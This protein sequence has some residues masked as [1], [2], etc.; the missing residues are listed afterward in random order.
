MIT[1]FC[2]VDGIDDEIELIRR[3]GVDKF[4]ISIIVEERVDFIHTRITMRPLIMGLLNFEKLISEF[5]KSEL[6]NFGLI[7]KSK[8]QNMQHRL[9]KKA[10]SFIDLNPNKSGREKRSIE[11][12]GNLIAKAFGNPGPEDWRK[13][14][15]NILA[16]KNAIARQRDNSILLHHTIDSNL[17]YIEKHNEILKKFAIDLQSDENRISMTENSMTELENYFKIETLYDAINEIIESLIDIKRDGKIGRCNFRGFSKDF[18]ITNLRKIESNRF[19]IS[20]VFASWEWENYFKYEMCTVALN[21]DEIW[22]TMRIPIIKPSEKMARII[23]NPSFIWIK[24]EMDNLGIEVSFF[25]EI[26]HDIFAVMS[27]S[28]FETC[29]ILGTTRICNIRKTKFKESRPF[30]VPIAISSNRLILIS[31]VS[32][33]DN[34]KL[35]TECNDMKQTFSLDKFAFI[36]IPSNCEIKNKHFEVTMKHKNEFNQDDIEIEPIKI[37]EYKK[38]ANLSKT[39]EGFIIEN[40]TRYADKDEFE[41][42]TNLTTLALNQI[43]LNHEGISDDI[44]L[45]KAG[46]ISGSAIIG[47]LGLIM[48]LIYVYKKFRNSKNDTERKNVNLNVNVNTESTTNDDKEVKSNLDAIIV[49]NEIDT[50]ELINKQ[51]RKK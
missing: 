10:E 35:E 38:L 8:L 2:A 45:I 3:E 16:M 48:I 47:C 49:E 37:L 6:T 31:N 20:P 40:L 46:G 44:K 24:N 34:Y 32:I 41:K 4:D 39:R 26:E 7:L 22:T 28:N 29:S 9:T 36:K 15:A 25:K 50:D 23:P 43:N 19:G 11:F 13:N 12:I 33:F 14:N 18:L 42:N 1:M 27:Q 5:E 30:T 21:R 51:F 17:H